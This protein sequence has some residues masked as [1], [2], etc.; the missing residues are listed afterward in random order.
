M[1]TSNE[2]ELK[3]LVITLK[4]A[5][6]FTTIID[7]NIKRKLKISK[8][9]KISISLNVSVASTKSVIKQLNKKSCLK[10]FLLS[11]SSLK[12][13][14][15]ASEI[16]KAN[17]KTTSLQKTKITLTQETLIKKIL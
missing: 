8:L 2:D 9:L 10:N 12:S 14:N 1:R 4:V 7:K 15:S 5:T 6:T 13:Q 16:T 17:V 11:C 3:N